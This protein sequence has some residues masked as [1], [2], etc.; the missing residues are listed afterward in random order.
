VEDH[1]VVRFK[2]QIAMAIAVRWFMDYYLV[3]RCSGGGGGTGG[4]LHGR[5]V[6]YHCVNNLYLEIKRGPESIYKY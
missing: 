6:K 1:I 5:E 2:W 4:L 3:L